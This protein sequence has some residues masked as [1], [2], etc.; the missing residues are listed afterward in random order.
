MWSF[1]QNGT[2]WPKSDRQ[3]AEGWDRRINPNTVYRADV[4]ALSEDG[5]KESNWNFTFR[6]IL[7]NAPSHAVYIVPSVSFSRLN[8]DYEGEVR[9]QYDTVVD[10]SG[11]MVTFGDRMI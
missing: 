10:N 7:T 9:V 5:N 11:G 1:G 6:I 8:T 4:R 3:V 2:L